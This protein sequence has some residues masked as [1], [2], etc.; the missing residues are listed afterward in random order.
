MDT[1]QQLDD[2]YVESEKTLAAIRA[3]L[4]VMDQEVKVVITV[5]HNIFSQSCHKNILLKPI[6]TNFTSTMELK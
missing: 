1:L 3:N 2:K 6:L 4:R 5:K